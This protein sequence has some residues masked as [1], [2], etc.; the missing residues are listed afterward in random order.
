M[1][2]V[3][4][5]VLI[6]FVFGCTLDQVSTRIVLTRKNVYESNPYTKALM[7]G[8]LWLI[9]D[10]ALVVSLSA[11]ALKASTILKRWDVAYEYIPYVTPL[12]VGLIRMLAG[13]HNI[14]LYFTTSK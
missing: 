8:G 7:D 14:L 1:K 4:K 6:I 2:L 10:V 12:L 3:A 9:V 5:V 11:L 13:I